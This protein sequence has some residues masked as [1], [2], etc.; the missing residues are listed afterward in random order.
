MA[1]SNSQSSVSSTAS[2]NIVVDDTE[3]EACGV[4]AKYH[5]SPH[6]SETASD[7]TGQGCDFFVIFRFCTVMCY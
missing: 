7:A 4:N 2:N 1:S 3:A 5:L 6:A